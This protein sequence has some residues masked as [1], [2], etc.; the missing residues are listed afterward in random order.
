MLQDPNTN[1]D[2]STYNG[3]YQSDRYHGSPPSSGCVVKMYINT[4]GYR[5]FD[6]Y[7]RSNGEN[8]WSYTIAVQPDVDP[9]NYSEAMNNAVADT[10]GKA[11]GTTSIDGYMKVT[12][13][14][15]G[16]S[17]R[18]CI[19][20]IHKDSYTV[21][22]DRGYVLIP[23]PASSDNSIYLPDLNDTLYDEQHENEIIL[24]EEE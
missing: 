9:S 12:Y 13:E 23:K 20:Y 16:G 8:G 19:A 10:N 6:V 14:L 3:V 5:T 2:M 1:P 24:E 11:T 18:I 7:I 21:G 15:D 17:H 4:I 22:D